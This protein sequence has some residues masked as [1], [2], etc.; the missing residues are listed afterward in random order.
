M[1]ELI[2]KKLGKQKTIL[3]DL[4]LID[5]FYEVCLLHVA[6]WMNAWMNFVILLGYKCCLWETFIVFQWFIV[7]LK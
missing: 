1:G 5:S 6:I 2:W 4:L 3:H 7:F